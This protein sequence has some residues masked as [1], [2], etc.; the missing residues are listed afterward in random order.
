MEQSAFERRAPLRL[1]RD[2]LGQLL[3]V[4]PSHAV[5]GAHGVRYCRL[6]WLARLDALTRF[7]VDGLDRQ[8]QLLPVVARPAPGAVAV[9][10][11]NVVGFS[12]G[13][14]GPAVLL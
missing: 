7:R 3:R 13:P 14:T 11:P 5:E 4:L 9:P 6:Q 2:P 1:H 12:P 8:R 10:P